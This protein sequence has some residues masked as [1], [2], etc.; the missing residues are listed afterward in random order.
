MICFPH[1]DACGGKNKSILLASQG[2]SAFLAPDASREDSVALDQRQGL[3][4][5]ESQEASS[6]TNLSIRDWRGGQSVSLGSF[7]VAKLGQ[8]D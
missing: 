4:E 8:E 2:L 7:W 1:L 5:G 3:G 6:R